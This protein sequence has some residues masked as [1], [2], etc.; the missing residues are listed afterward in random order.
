VLG[1]H[2]EERARIGHCA[3]DLLA[4][5]DDAGVL[6]QPVDVRRREARHLRGIEAGES[7]DGSARAC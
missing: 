1:L 4:M 6:H 3:R 5:A 7:R 2:G